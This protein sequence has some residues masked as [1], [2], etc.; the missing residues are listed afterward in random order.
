[1][2]KKFTFMVAALLAA[3]P[4][5]F[6]QISN[7]IPGASQDVED[8]PK[9][10]Y[11]LELGSSNLIKSSVNNATGAIS[12]GATE[13]S[14]GKL[15]DATSGVTLDN[16]LW[17]V[18]VSGSDNKKV[19]LKNKATGYYLAFN[20]DADAF[21]SN[22]IEY[23][24]DVKLIKEFNLTNDE[25]TFGYKK[26]DATTETTAEVKFD[27]NAFA[28]E[29]STG[30]NTIKL[31]KVSNENVTVDELVKLG[32][33]FTLAFEGKPTGYE[34]FEGVTVVE[35]ASGDKISDSFTNTNQF[36][37][38]KGKPAM[39]EGKFDLE[40]STV[41]VLSATS[42]ITGVEAPNGYKYTTVKGEKLLTETEIEE[43]ERKVESGKYPLLNAIFVAEKN[44][45]KDGKIVLAQPAVYTAT[46]NEWG[47]E[48]SATENPAVWVS[49]TGNTGAA[50][51]NA[52]TVSDNAAWLTPSLGTVVDVK[53]L[54]KGKLVVNIL[55]SENTDNTVMKKIVFSSQ[56]EGTKAVLSTSTDET[57]EHKDAIY[58]Q[59]VVSADKDAN[60]VTFENRETGVSIDKVTLFKTPKANVYT[61]SYTGDLFD[62][63]FIE[64][65]TVENTTQWDGYL[66]LDK[67]ALDSEYTLSVDAEDK[68]ADIELPVIAT[69]YTSGD[70]YA[71]LAPAE[72]K[73]EKDVFTFKLAQSKDADTEKLDTVFVNVVKYG[74]YKDGKFTTANDTL[75]AISY[76][77][78]GLKNA[79][80]KVETGKTDKDND[81]VLSS[82]YLNSNANL[83]D[84]ETNGKF[85]VRKSGDKYQI[86]IADQEV[87]KNFVYNHSKNQAG[88]RFTTDSNTDGVKTAQLF[89][90]NPVAA[91]PV[92]EFPESHVALEI[93]GAY[94]G[95][96][97]D[98]NAIMTN[99][100][101]MLKSTNVDAAFSFY[102]FS[103]DKEA[104]KTPSY[105]LSSNGKMM[106]EPKAEVEA[107]V[108]E[109]NDLSPV[110][111]AEK[112][113]ELKDK[114]ATYYKDG[115]DE[116][117]MLIKFQQ[118]KY[119][120]AEN[121]ALAE[122]TVKGDALKAYKFTAYDVD[123]Q[124]V[125][126]N[127]NGLY[128]T[129]LNEAVVLQDNIDNAAKFNVVAA[130][131][132][133]SNEGV[134]ATEV[135]VVAN[136]GS[137]VVKNAAGKNVVV[138]TILG[139][140][141]A[142]EVLT[143]DNATINV[144]AGIVVVAVEGESFKV[145]VK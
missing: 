2:N 18:V 101:T 75:K 127:A 19:T 35:V 56:E 52:Q 12:F 103:A 105:Y 137:I 128:I 20:D 64:L 55:A 14:S 106:Y 88:S 68:F 133:T 100:T 78:T 57:N 4:S 110:F 98:G 15:T 40:N 118:A 90:L 131:A 99:D 30:T 130:E 67:D 53:T 11:Y 38:V 69:T 79:G 85:I 71:V 26:G 84:N 60:T 16:Y 96:K 121:I 73:D 21:V 132:P 92:Y 59:W 50:L 61:A 48:P 116:K 135:K 66:N 107:I 22:A 77:F 63:C 122:D 7:V 8:A 94:L 80:K 47:A 24:K 141:V 93:N 120:D 49:A 70:S 13:L 119:V 111:D 46:D 83:Y 97:A 140:V 23:S 139:Q 112:I 124:A 41:V 86:K 117:D 126:K 5:A 42:G 25:L 104:T 87:Y 113:A 115:N 95:S 145:N 33:N 74:F 62:D 129:V 91:A 109:L 138:S 17:E 134:S 10:Y 3:G 143:S 27:S 108:K 43:A 34:T 28:I 1:M 36:Y 6:A 81:K 31:S 76:S 102:A 39:K 136:N 72:N 51:V 114:K 123:G 37:L 89:S 65:R 54:V 142:N 125:L 32:E 45:N 144:P 29:E 82:F 9:A 44:T 58:A